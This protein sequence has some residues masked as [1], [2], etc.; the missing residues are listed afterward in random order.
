[1]QPTP[2]AN[3]LVTALPFYYGWVIL[4]CIVFACISRA[5]PA[6]ATLSIF[7]TPMTAEFGW[8]R[9]AIAGAVSLG[10]ILAAIGSPM[11]GAYLDRRGA[12]LILCLAV[13]AT[14]LTLM[15]L[16]TIE[17][18]LAFYLLY[19]IA[20][21]SWAGPYDLGIWGALNNWFVAKRAFAASIVTLAQMSGLIMMPLISWWVIENYGWRT[22]WLVIGSL[23]LIVGFLPTWAFMIRKPEDV[24]LLP[25]GASPRD[26]ATPGSGTSSTT[27]REEPAFTRAEALRTR[28]FWMLALYTALI[29]PVQAGMS[30][31]QA[32]HLIERG[33]S[34]ATVATVVSLFSLASAVTGFGY[35]LLQRWMN[36]KAALGLAG[37]L[38]AASAVVMISA[39]TPAA[40]M[41]GGILFGLGMGGLHTLLPVAWADTFGRRNFGAIRGIALTIQ[42]AAQA[43]GPVV[44]GILRDFSGDYMASL[45]LFASLSAL[46]GIAAVAIRAPGGLHRGP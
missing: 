1:M 16:S 20:R 12:R 26:P 4:G 3:R 31:H 45:V 36:V 11:I 41:V 6:V 40:A 46:A 33:L 10:G 5:G 32:A 27:T 44:S 15:A 9:T 30:L 28:A 17:S 8:S 14:G 24:G 38:L 21:M 19:C 43:A 39:A 23:V 35:G 7:V 22:G 13:L 37:V 42:V 2:V 29:Y 25:D 34:T 18:L